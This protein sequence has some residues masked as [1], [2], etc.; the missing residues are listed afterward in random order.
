MRIVVALVAAVLA[1]LIVGLPTGV[2]TM[3]D[4]RYCFEHEARPANTAFHEETLSFF[5]PGPECRF[6]LDDGS[7]VVVGPGWW[8]AMSL[9]AALIA[10]LVVPRVTGYASA[11]RT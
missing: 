2:I 5:P 10:A 1:F 3:I 7:E 9:M 6:S 4:Q 11:S 8:P